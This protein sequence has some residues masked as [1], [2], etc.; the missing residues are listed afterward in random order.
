MPNEERT[1]VSLFIDWLHVSLEA[2]PFSFGLSENGTFCVD[3]RECT[4]SRA[5]T[6]TP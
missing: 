2:T 4:Q 6:V 1:S 3:Q 5:K